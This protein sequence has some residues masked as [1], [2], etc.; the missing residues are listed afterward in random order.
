MYCR[1]GK[2]VYF[3]LFIDSFELKRLLICTINLTVYSST[4]LYEYNHVFIAER[5]GQ[6]GHDDA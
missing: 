3:T 5:Y 2:D 6:P 1:P 4:I